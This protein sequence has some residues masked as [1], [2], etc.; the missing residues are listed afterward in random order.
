MKNVERVAGQL[1]LPVLPSCDNAFT[2]LATPLVSVPIATL[3][4]PTM[5]TD[6]T[7]ILENLEM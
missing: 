4:H 2:E 7:T 1:L 5:V 6:G 3:A